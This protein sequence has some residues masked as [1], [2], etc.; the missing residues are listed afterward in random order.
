MLQMMQTANAAFNPHLP[1]FRLILLALLV[2]GVPACRMRI[3]ITV[4]LFTRNSW[5]RAFVIVSTAA[6]FYPLLANIIPDVKLIST[7]ASQVFLL[8]III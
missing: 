5:R 4:E 2:W 6:V 7:K 1:C 3:L 8:Y